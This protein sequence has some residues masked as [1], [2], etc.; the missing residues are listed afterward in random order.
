VAS[1]LF[2]AVVGVGISLG[3]I[4][5][6]GGAVSHDEEPEAAE[7]TAP[8]QPDGTAGPEAGVGQPQPRADADAADAA[9][10][11]DASV[12]AAHV[13]TEDA[14]ATTEDAIAAAFCDVPWPITKSGRE[15]CGPY[16]ECALTQAPW[17][18]GPDQNGACK[19][20]PIECVDA[21]WQCLGNSTPT[22]SPASPVPCQ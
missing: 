4:A 13:T 9:V 14:D 20:H 17:C 8:P 21:Q 10:S 5:A 16:E 11:S 6:C 12:E 18:F 22:N 7:P 15:V 1:K 2:H 3:S 19:L